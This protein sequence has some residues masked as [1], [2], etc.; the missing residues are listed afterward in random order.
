MPCIL[1][2]HFFYDGLRDSIKQLI[3]VRKRNGIRADSPIN[4]WTAESDMYVA[5]VQDLNKND[6]V[7]LKLGPRYDMVRHARRHPLVTIAVNDM[8]T[9]GACLPKKEDGWKFVASGKDWAL[10]EKPPSV[11]AAAEE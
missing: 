7:V 3:S 8:H 10:W 4:I 2:E 6:R 11:T 1:H 9:Q 5:A